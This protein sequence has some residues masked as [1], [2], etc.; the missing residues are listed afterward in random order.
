MKILLDT[1]T[2]LWALFDNEKLSPVSELLEN[3]NN[4]IFVSVASFWELEIKHKT[5]PQAMPYSAQE[6]Y[7]IVSSHTDFE[8]LPISTSHIFNLGGFI[9]QN[10]HR[11]PFD[12]L[13]LSVALS[14]DLILLTHD[15][16]INKYRG[17]KLLFF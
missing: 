14:D 6:I 12:H 9:E 7:S 4:D 15:E 2:L 17:V 10:I 1:H 11:D 3:T 8:I 16:K 5:N 13:L